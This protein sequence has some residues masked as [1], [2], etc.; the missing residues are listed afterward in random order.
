V[1]VH[2]AEHLTDFAGWVS[3]ARNA[4]SAALPP[5]EGRHI[6]VYPKSECLAS[7]G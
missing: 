3:S 6:V 2:A 1:L 5:D 7:I 4:A